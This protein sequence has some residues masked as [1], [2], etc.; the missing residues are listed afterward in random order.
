MDVD[1]EERTTAGSEVSH[2]Q[3]VQRQERGADPHGCARRSRSRRC[4]SSLLLDNRFSEDHIVSHS[5]MRIAS[6]NV[7]TS[8]ELIKLVDDDTEVVGID[9]GSSSTR[10]CR[11]RATRSRI[12]ARVIVAGLIRIISAGRSS[13]CRSCWRSRIS[14]KTLAICVVCGDP[15]NHT[16][17]LG[18]QQGSRAR[19]RDGM[20]E[21]R[22]RHCLIPHWR[23]RKKR[24]CSSGENRASRHEDLPR[25]RS[26]ETVDVFLSLYRLIQKRS[27]ARC[28]HR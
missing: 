12:A 15:A 3:H 25:R 5:D 8:D 18:G 10:T 20:H 19:R 4:R 23:P 28:A 24:R 9:E 7:K 26:F 11:P 6:V 21:A 1:V 16:Q 27:S 17:R 13:R 2:R 14:P 22:C